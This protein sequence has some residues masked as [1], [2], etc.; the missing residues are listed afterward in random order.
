MEKE[1]LN[2]Q[3]G[4]S[5]LET[6]SMERKKAPGKWAGQIKESMRENGN[7]TRKMEREYIEIKSEK[8]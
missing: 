1:V 6:F 4:A 3:M 2:F 8:W 5:L 7:R